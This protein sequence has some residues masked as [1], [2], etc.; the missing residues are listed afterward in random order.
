M[1]RHVPIAT[2]TIFLTD[3]KLTLGRAPTV[4]AMQFPMNAIRINAP[5]TRVAWIAMPMGYLTNVIFALAFEIPTQ[6]GSLIGVNSVPVAT[7]EL[8]PARTMF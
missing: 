4:T 5:V 6:T 3:A 7:G 8:E 2:V 1:T